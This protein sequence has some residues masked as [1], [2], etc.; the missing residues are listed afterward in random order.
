MITIETIIIAALMIGVGLY[1]TRRPEWRIYPREDYYAGK[2]A[3][4]RKQIYQSL[5]FVAALLSL[6]W[7]P[8][9]AYSFLITLVVAFPFLLELD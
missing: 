2:L 4:R 7:R 6:L 8:W 1:L 3:G 9:M 5:W